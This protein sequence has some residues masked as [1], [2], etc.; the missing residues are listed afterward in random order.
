MNIDDKK[1]VLNEL[2]NLYNQRN[3]VKEDSA[4]RASI[5]AIIKGKEDSFIKLVEEERNEN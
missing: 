4:G 2:L 1:V 3:F 5:E